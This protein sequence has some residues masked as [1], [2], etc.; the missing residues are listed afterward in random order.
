MPETGTLAPKRAE[1]RDER[2]SAAA[3][4][5]A[6]ARKEFLDRDGVIGVGYGFKEKD[7]RI[8]RDEPAILIYVF[9]KKDKSRIPASQMIPPTFNNVP[10]DVIV[11][12]P[13]SNPI[14]DAP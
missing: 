6:A 2:F 14:H 10:T 13:G 8:L 4:N 3:K 7:G 11:V 12:K 5:L 1:I 9:E